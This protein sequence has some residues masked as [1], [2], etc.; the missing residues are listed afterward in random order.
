MRLFVALAAL[1]AASA[2]SAVESSLSGT[3][4]ARLVTDYLYR[5]Y[6]KSDGR[7]SLQIHGGVTAANGVY[8]GL[9]LN[10]V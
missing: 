2:C 6:S 8:A 7:M 3:G 9:W 4:M 5:G 10:R 1:W